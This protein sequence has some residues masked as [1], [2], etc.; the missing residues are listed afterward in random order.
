MNINGRP[1]YINGV[2]GTN[3]LDVA[4]A[5]GANAFRTWGGDVAEIQKNSQLASENHMY[6]M[7]GIYL[8]KDSAL[9]TNPQYRQ[10]KIEEVTLLA[11]TF[12]ND[13]SIFAWGIGNEI[14]LANAANTPIAWQFVDT[15][16]RLMK[17][18]DK[19]HLVSTVISHNPGA[20]DMIA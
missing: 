3:R 4:V 10:E 1:I 2:G 5:S 9:Y 18:I 17:S 15:L 7:Q 13:T 6:I 8:P 11:Q 12:K 14:E 20:L 19:R 16:A